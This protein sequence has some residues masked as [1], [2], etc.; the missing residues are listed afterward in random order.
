MPHIIVKLYPGKSENQKIN[1]AEDITKV[2]CENLSLK[3]SS[4]S[5]S[6]EEIPAELWAKEVY[7]KDIIDNK[8]NLYKKPGYKPKEN[9]L[10]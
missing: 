1:L 2:V 8:E 3:E 7:K 4:V 6:I 10:E 5:V 9:E